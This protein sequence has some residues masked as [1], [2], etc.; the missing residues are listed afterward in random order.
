MQGYLDIAI[1]YD[2]VK[3]NWQVTYKGEKSEYPT[4]QELLTFIGKKCIVLQTNNEYQ[5]QA[6]TKELQQ[7]FS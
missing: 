5:Y 3:K 6:S 1:Y 4:I 2:T 7:L